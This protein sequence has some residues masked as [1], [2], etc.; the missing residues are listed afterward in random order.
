MASI[1]PDQSMDASPAQTA[2]VE[3]HSQIFVR[4]LDEEF[5]AA[6]REAAISLGYAAWDWES[7]SRDRFVHELAKLRF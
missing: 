6:E 2:W 5:I 4:S 1:T 7:W 3:A